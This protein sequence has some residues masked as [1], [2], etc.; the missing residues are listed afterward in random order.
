ME[1]ETKSYKHV[2]YDGSKTFEYLQMIR[3]HVIQPLR[4][5][6]VGESCFEA[7]IL[8]FG[9]ADGLGK[10][11]HDDAS[12]G[13]GVR[14]QFF[15]SRLGSPYAKHKAALWGLRNS[16]AHNAMNVACFMSK[17]EQAWGKHL[18]ECEGYLFIQ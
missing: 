18:E 16:L 1:R 14:F 9:A 2:V 10:L 12:A 4:D 11:I 7:A 13:T 15:I 6:A 3:Q 8:I 5:T 17:M